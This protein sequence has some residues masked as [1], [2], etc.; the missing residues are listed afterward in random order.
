MLSTTNYV[1]DQ[2]DELKY[3]IRT[4]S[5]IFSKMFVLCSG[6]VYSSRLWI[7]SIYWWWEQLQN[8]PQLIYMSLN[9]NSVYCVT[10]R[11][12]EPPD[13]CKWGGPKLRGIL[14]FSLVMLSRVARYCSFAI[15]R[16][17]RL[18][19]WSAFSRKTRF[20]L[21]WVINLSMGGK[22]VWISCKT[23]EV[24]PPQ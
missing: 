16:L 20:W 3:I 4:V 24:E 11:S 18:L 1:T 15:N 8:T 2:N 14:K 6:K 12:S 10:P 22:P 19:D 13:T 7:V 21:M 5:L 17:I 9:K 23:W